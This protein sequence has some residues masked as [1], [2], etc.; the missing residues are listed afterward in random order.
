MTERGRDQR[1]SPTPG[2]LCAAVARAPRESP[3]LDALTL[4]WGVGVLRA[5]ICL[6]FAV[7]LLCARTLGKF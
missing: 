1:S 7:S 6:G 4:L 5:R 3:A 2:A